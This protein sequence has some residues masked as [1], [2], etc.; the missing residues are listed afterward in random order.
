MLSFTNKTFDEIEV[1]ASVTVSRRLSVNEVEALAL[2]SGDVDAFHLA[3]HEEGPHGEGVFAKAVG[4][5]AFISGLLARQLPGPGTTVLAQDLRFDGSLTVGDEVSA[6]VTAKEKRADGNLIEPY[7]YVIGKDGVIYDRFEGPAARNIIEPA[8]K[9]VAAGQ[10]Y[11][12]P[13]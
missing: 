10:V 8:V 9:A 13:K 7:V 11:S 1:G 2:V 4:A 12:A 5:E 3:T 6:T